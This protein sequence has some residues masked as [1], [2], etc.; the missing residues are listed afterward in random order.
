MITKE[1]VRNIIDDAIASKLQGNKSV[2]A[3][4][5]A[6]PV[7][8]PTIESPITPEPEPEPEPKPEP[9]V[10]ALDE[11]DAI[12]LENLVLKQELEKKQ[13]ELED[14][15]RK[16]VEEAL[17]ESQIELQMFLVKKYDVDTSTSQL[18]INPQALTLT[19]TPRE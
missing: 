4:P 3:Q 5:V 17:R 6:Q 13:R 19:I 16:Q 10:K 11:I 12:R 18:V 1:D 15:R 2:A 8:Q 14:R 7:A 9:I